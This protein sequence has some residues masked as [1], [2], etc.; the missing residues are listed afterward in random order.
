MMQ[1]AV[2]KAMN[3]ALFVPTIVGGAGFA[4]WK[5]EFQNMARSFVTGPGRVARIL[6]L[7]AV[8]LNWKSLPF[9]WTVSISAQPQLAPSSLQ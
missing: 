6:L 4:A 9:A 2:R 8:V 5:Y 1:E 3:S 7:L